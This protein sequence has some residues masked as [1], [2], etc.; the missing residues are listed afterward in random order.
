MF[1]RRTLICVCLTLSLI[2]LGAPDT[3]A[4]EMDRV[5]TVMTQNMDNGTDFGLIFNASPQNLLAQVG[6]TYAEV[7][8][9]NIPERAKAVAKEIDIARPDLVALQEVFT[10][11]VGPIGGPAT[12]VTYD[13]L[14]SLLDALGQRGLHYAPVAVL[15]NLDTE[16]PASV[17]SAGIFDVRVTD[18]DVVL[19]RTDLPVSQLRLSNI[20]AEHFTTNA[21]LPNP[22]FGGLTIL[23]GWISVD[24]IM[25][26]KPFRFVTTHLESLSPQ[27]QAAQ[28]GELLRGPAN[29]RLPV[30]FAGDF[31]SDAQSNDPA[32]NAAYRILVGVGF[33]F[34]D[35]WRV[36][37]PS[38]P[39]FTWPLHG[40]D[41]FTPSATPYQRIDLVLARGETHPITVSLVGNRQ[42]DLTPSGLWPSDHAGLVA[43]FVIEP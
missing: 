36:T 15:T 25:R 8:S 22:L 10:Y 37:H 27:I 4:S 28:A 17:P 21:V 26:G 24:G 23:R 29:T 6:T 2:G 32:Q 34:T 5:L 13:A 39:G 19:A 11:R 30:I 3:Q 12:T 1:G 31:N 42:V 40:E 20:Q 7:Q 43:S 18:H 41:P 14:Q 35:A 9:S 33:S 16:T 38:D